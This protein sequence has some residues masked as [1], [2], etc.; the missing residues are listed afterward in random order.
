MEVLKSHYLNIKKKLRLL[1]RPKVK[2]EKEK[3]RVYVLNLVSL[4]LIAFIVILVL[5]FVLKVIITPSAFTTTFLKYFIHLVLSL[6]YLVFLFYLSRK[7]KA[8]TAAILLLLYLFT[9][10]IKMTLCWQVDLSLIILFLVLSVFLAS[11]LLSPSYSF[12]FTTFSSL[13]A[14]VLSVLKSK[15]LSSKDLVWTADS[16]ITKNLIIFIVFF[17]FFILLCWLANREVEEKIEKCQKLKK[18][19]ERERNILAIKIQEVTRKLK[20]AQKKE[21]K[22]LEQLASFGRLSAGFFHELANPLT[23]ISLNMEEASSV[24]QD[25][26]LWEKFNNN[27]NRTVLATKKMGNFLASVRKQIANKDEKSDFSLNNEIEEI[28]EIL[29]P[30][31]KRNLVSLV[32][33]CEKNIHYNNS[34]IK[35]HQVAINLISNAIDSYEKNKEGKSRVVMVSL[36]ETKENIVFSVRDSGCGLSKELKEQIFKPFFSTKS[37]SSNSGLGLSLVNSIVKQDFGGRIKIESK[38]HKGT[39]FIIF[40]PKALPRS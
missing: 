34:Q 37:N 29:E 19:L 33:K 27:I 21:L 36:Y 31:A 40:L 15:G 38:K 32:F 35:F 8:K 30:R 11:V 3:R 22:H 24:C 9:L 2:I 5:I 4:S 7:S 13:T 28:I 10:I 14:F 39:K 25:S 26:P 17:L 12:F 18:E 23:A 6:A 1:V 20:E 16:I